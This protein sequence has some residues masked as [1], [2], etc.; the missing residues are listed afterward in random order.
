M[1]VRREALRRV[2]AAANARGAFV[3]GGGGKAGRVPCEAASPSPLL[4]VQFRE[5]T[6]EEIGREGERNGVRGQKAAFHVDP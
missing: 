2:K 1:W 6:V 5:N 3:C 4:Q